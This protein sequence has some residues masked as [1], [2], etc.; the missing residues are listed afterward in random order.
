A[1]AAGSQP[2]GNTF[3]DI[4]ATLNAIDE[5]RFDT[6]DA[7][8]EIGL[9]RSAAREMKVL[10]AKYASNPGVQFLL[11]DVYV[12]G[13]EPFKANSVLQK[14]FRQYVRHGGTNI[15]QRFWEILFPRAYWETYQAE[16]QRQG[17]DPYLLA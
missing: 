7:L 15:P 6:V 14:Q 2:S 17:V 5:P 13:G 1:A 12:R 16:G 3:P 10:A 9:N 8:L 11:A 4:E